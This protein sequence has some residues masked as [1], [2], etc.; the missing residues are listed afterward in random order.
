MADFWAQ[1]FWNGRYFAARYFG[2]AASGLPPYYVDAS[3]VIGG[4][5]HI[6]RAEASVLQPPAPPQYGGGPLLLL[7]VPR[8]APRKRHP[9][10][11][12]ASAVIGGNA[13]LTA[14]AK[15]DLRAG[16]EISSGAAL[17][18][19]PVTKRSF[20]RADNEFWLIAA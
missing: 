12:D 19:R 3:A 18:G 14:S 16:A 9:V 5:G 2:G 15:S 17:E 7:D 20:R 8:K 4:S 6:A 13:S 1:R 10:Y 11:V